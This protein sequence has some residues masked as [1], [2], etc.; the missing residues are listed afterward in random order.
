MENNIFQRN[1]KKRDWAVFL[2]ILTVW[3]I[4]MPDNA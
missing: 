1:L 2:E 3:G 4:S